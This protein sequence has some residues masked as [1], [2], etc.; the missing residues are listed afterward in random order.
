VKIRHYF[1]LIAAVLV[2]MTASV[3]GA[4]AYFTANDSASG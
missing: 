4:M 3:G 1:L 2:L